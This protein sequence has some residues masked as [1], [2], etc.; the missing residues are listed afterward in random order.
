M[1]HT[2][3]LLTVLHDIDNYRDRYCATC[4]HYE[5]RFRGPHG[6]C[7]KGYRP[8]APDDGCDDWQPCCPDWQTNPVDCRK[9]LK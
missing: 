3:D 4:K 2:A 9:D 6:I 5:W 8:M 1:T 7:R